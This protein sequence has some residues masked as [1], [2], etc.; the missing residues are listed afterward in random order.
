MNFKKCLTLFL[1]VLIALNINIIS[2]AVDE[3]D[4]D[5]WEYVWVIFRKKNIEK[6]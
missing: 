6:L 4:P 1:T 2:F 5:A 3:I